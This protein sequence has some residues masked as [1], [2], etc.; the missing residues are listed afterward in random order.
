M[1][2]RKGDKVKFLNEAGGGIIVNIIDNKK[3]I[4]QIEDGFEIPVLLDQLIV[5]E[6]TNH[7]NKVIE[8][9]IDKPSLVG[10]NKN[11]N[12]QVKNAHIKSVKEF[13]EIAKPLFAITS[14]GKNTTDEERVFILYL[15]NDGDYR[16]SYIVSFE[17]ENKLK[18]LDKG[19]LETDTVANLGSIQ[20]KQLL[21]F[22]AIVIDILFYSEYEFKAQIPIHYRLNLQAGHTFISNFKETE[23]FDEPAYLV[24]LIENR[25]FEEHLSET[26]NIKVKD[27]IDK[28]SVVKVDEIEEVDLHIEE[29]IDNDANLSNGEIM[30]LQ[31][32]RFTTSLDGA[33]NGKTKKIV[34]IHG[35]GNG[36]LRYEL[37]KTLDA[38]YPDLKY[39]DASFAEYGYGATMVIIR[40]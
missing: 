7:K 8:E 17:K 39:Q 13:N 20:Y 2:I 18:L 10:S 22:Q 23:Y 37:R 38:K 5:S 34:F 1:E 29:I 16:L 35:L 14:V 21:S 32:A 27:F 12:K 19:E 9:I 30:N 15:L 31:M 11:I 26:K 25:I 28:K 24:D 33:I 3:A 36:K 6:P 4:V 40:K